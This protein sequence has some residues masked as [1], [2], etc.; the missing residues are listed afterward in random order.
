MAVN[1]RYILTEGLPN[2]RMNKAFFWESTTLIEHKQTF[3]GQSTLF[4]VLCRFGPSQSKFNIH[5]ENVLKILSK[6]T[7]LISIFW[8]CWKGTYICILCQLFFS[9]YSIASHSGEGSRSTRREPPTMG[10][11]L[12][13]F[14]TCGC[15]SNAPF[16]THLAKGQVNFCHHLA[17]VVRR[18]LFQKS[19]PLKLLDQLYPNL[20]WIITMVFSLKIVSGDGMHQST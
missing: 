14:I 10:K 9:M 12:V 4:F 2:E 1:E 13:N 8:S 7:E 6:T 20:V 16:L 11:Q 17:S 18:K 5:G 19:S 15:E 3:M